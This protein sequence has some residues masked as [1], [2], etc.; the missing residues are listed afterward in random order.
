MTSDGWRRAV[1]WMGDHHGLATRAHLRELGLA[2]RTRVRRMDEGLLV[3]V[4]SRVVALPG[5]RL[6]LRTTTRA[7]VLAL[8]E[9]IPTGP[10][11]A[12][13]IGAGPWDPEN[14]GST[15]WLVHPR[16]RVVRARYVTHPGMRSAHAGGVRVARPAD[17]ALDLIRLLPSDEAIAVAQ[18]ALQLGTLTLGHMTSAQARLVGTSGNAQL[19]RIVAALGEGTRSEGER[20]LVRLLR[21]HSI[22]G[23]QANLPVRVGGRSRLLDVAFPELRLAIEFDGAAFHTDAARFQDDR[24]RQNDLVAAGWTVLRFTWADLT[25]RP[26]EVIDRIRA[27]LLRAESGGWRRRT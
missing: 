9:A 21:A 3:A 1:A 4:N 16:S 17:A 12:C 20:R 15:V 19:A 23:W 11:A 24:R 22:T 26:D 25:D 14:L 8:P 2:D 6:D 5:T 27:A 13:M 10:S 18:R 7:A